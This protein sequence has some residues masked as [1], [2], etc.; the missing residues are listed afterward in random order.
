MRE[1]NRGKISK[2]I[3]IYIYKT[4]IDLAICV[5]EIYLERV[6]YEDR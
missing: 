1:R 2:R 6:F 5:N 3:Y 4:M